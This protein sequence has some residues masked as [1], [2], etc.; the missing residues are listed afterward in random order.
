MKKI[1][2]LNY[3]VGNLKSIR[4]AMD[5]CGFNY[6]VSSEVNELAGCDRI[7]V[8]GVGAFSAGIQN[9]RRL[10]LDKFLLECFQK[11]VPMM[12]ICL[13]YQLMCK[14]STE[15]GF[16]EGLGI[17]SAEVKKIEAPILPHVG[18]SSLDVVE[19]SLADS[20]YKG[21]EKNRYYFVHTYAVELTAEIKSDS[22]ITCYY[23][24]KFA[25]SAR[26]KNA[27]GVQYHPEKSSEQGL[28]VLRNFYN[29]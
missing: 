21:I 11:E 28:Q 5:Y 26:N 16:N 22:S 7:V 19:K 4:N 13:G 3:E 20:L 1:G 12:G 6:V 17:F 18:W 25:S 14:S 9:L 15:F 2:I 27:F 29:F 23:D 8:P 10:G 24:A